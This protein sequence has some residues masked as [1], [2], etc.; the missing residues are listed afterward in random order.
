MMYFLPML[1]VFPSSRY[2]SGIS[3]DHSAKLK[4]SNVIETNASMCQEKAGVDIF[5]DTLSWYYSLQL[6]NFTAT[7]VA[8][9]LA[10]TLALRK[11]PVNYLTVVIVTGSNLLGCT[12]LTSSSD[13]TILNLLETLFISVLGLAHLIWVT[14]HRSL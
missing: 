3:Q 6:P 12:T 2:L 9:L 1:P 14:S 7:L 10:I 5:S 13:S 8:E 4:V 11:L